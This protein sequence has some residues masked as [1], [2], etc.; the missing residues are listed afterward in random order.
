MSST[1]SRRKIERKDCL[2]DARAYVDGRPA[3]CCRVRDITPHGAKLITES[4]ITARKMLLFL[5]AIGEVWATEVRWRRG[6]TAIGVRFLHGEADLVEA[7]NLSKPDSFA[8]HL[9]VA[10]VAETAHRLSKSGAG[11]SRTRSTLAKACPPARGRLS[12]AD[13]I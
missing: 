5:P 13:M 6:G 8:L 12:K 11:N 1:L 3:I 9:Q 2:L 10:Q 7:E 4:A